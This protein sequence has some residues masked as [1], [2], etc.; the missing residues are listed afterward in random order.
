NHHDV[1]A[2]V[3]Q[4]GHQV[5]LFGAG[6]G[7]VA[8]DNGDTGRRRLLDGPFDVG[9]ARA[10]PGGAHRGRVRV[11]A[12]PGAPGCRAGD[13]VAGDVHRALGQWHQV[14]VVTQQGD[15]GVGRLLC[16]PGVRLDADHRV[17]RVDVDDVVVD[18]TAVVLHRQD[19]VDGFLQQ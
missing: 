9:P 3:P 2:R 13:A 10:R 12:G 18:D 5:L 6:V 8:G 19:A 14:G 4:R 17:D 7:G 1:P 11:G 16:E 15:R